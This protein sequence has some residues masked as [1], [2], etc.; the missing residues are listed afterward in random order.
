VKKE[1]RARL[2]KTRGR[3]DDQSRGFPGSQG[4]SKGAYCV[5]RKEGKPPP[6]KKKGKKRP[7]YKRKR[8]GKAPMGGEK[9]CSPKG[10]RGAKD[11]GK[12]GKKALPSIVERVKTP[13]MHEGGE[14][15]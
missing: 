8:K 5:K 13:S 12:K 6:R 1:K 2:N 14:R 15:R 11:P 3:G 4:P 9:I 7:S 10:G